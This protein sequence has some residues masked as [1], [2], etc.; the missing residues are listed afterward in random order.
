MYEDTIVAIATPIGEGGIGIVRVSGKDARA[1][2][3]KVFAQGLRHRRLSYGKIIDPRDGA[4]LDEVMATFMQAPRS[5]TREDTVEI[6]GHGGAVALQGVIGVLLRCGA[7]MA[8]PGE[9]TLRAFLN[10]RIDLAQAEAVL[11]VIQ[12]KTDAG[13]RI[14][15]DGLQGKLSGPLRKLRKEL[16]ELLAYLT[17]R[18]DFPEDDIPPQ[19]VL[20]PLRGAREEVGRLI[21]SA[22]TGIIFRQGVRAAIVGRPNVGKSS[23]LNRLLGQ[24]RAIV[25]PVPGTTRDTVEEVVNIQSIPF[26]L[27]D[28]AGMTEA[29]DL[30]EVLGV[31][32]TKRAVSRADLL[33]LVLDLSQPI[34]EEDRAIMQRVEGKSVVAVGNKSDLPMRASLA[35]LP[36]DP[37]KT[38]MTTG[39]GLE[40][41]QERM[42]ATV[43]GGR[44]VTSDALLVSNP[45]HKTALEK[46]QEHLAQAEDSL[47]KGMPDDFVTIDLTSAL[48]AL[49]EITGETVTEE[50][51]ETIFSRFCIGK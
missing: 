42:V 24:D 38:S 19:D 36:W 47:L 10:G 18:I 20:A 35:D 3:A 2:V 13:L 32:R 28:T 8:N 25:T 11:D 43:L 50:L 45:R 6:Y 31:E 12:A 40:A 48:N 44:A 30:V 46:A 27:V 33:L 9:F 22:D 4:V 23:L 34:T 51:L 37:V 16:I 29:S 7:R 39:Q 49:G 1:V 26:V 17:A 41:L 15:M 14:A 5:Y 21:A